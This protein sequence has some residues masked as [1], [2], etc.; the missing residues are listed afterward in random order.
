MN[1]EEEKDRLPAWE[2]WRRA[3]ALDLTPEAPR[4]TLIS[5]L[6]RRFHGGV[7]R[8][9][10][11]LPRGRVPGDTA[12]AGLFE[13]WCALN[14]CRHG[15]A[16][17]DWL[18]ARGDQSIGAVE[19]GVSLL[20]RRVV[21]EWLRM[22]RPLTAQRSFQ[23]K[24]GPA[25][26][27]L[28]DLLPDPADAFMLLDEAAW[29]ARRLGEI[30]RDMNRAQRVALSARARGLPFTH[31]SVTAAA[32][33]RHAMLAK[34]HRILLLRL[35]G[36]IRDDFPGIPAETALDLFRRCVDELAHELADELTDDKKINFS[37]EQ[38]GFAG[39]MEEKE[40]P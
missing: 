30:R 27:T 40:S 2:A 18:F 38:R 9:A 23:G 3:C 21:R 39:C 25:G 7:R 34:H 13:S 6:A 10:A 37:V 31:P 28:E 15:K 16:Y 29:R 5:F 1:G 36:L 19:S 22:E 14:D 12:C 8:A 35:G 24:L 4:R 20:M 26:L 11:G 17:K 33:V 32:G